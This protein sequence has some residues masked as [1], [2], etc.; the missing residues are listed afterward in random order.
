MTKTAYK[1]QL[2]EKISYLSSS[3]SVSYREILKI[4]D[5]KIKFLIKSDS[6]RIQCYAKAHVL[7]NDE[8]VEVYSVPYSEMFTP[9]SLAYKKDYSKRPQDALDEFAKDKCRLLALT[10]EI[11]F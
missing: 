4:N 6:Y 1:E 10:K 3:Q 11:L 7:K 5:K 8:W 9:D 2:I